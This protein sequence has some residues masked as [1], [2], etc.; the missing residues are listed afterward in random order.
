MVGLVFYVGR[1]QPPAYLSRHWSNR[2]TRMGQ[3][4]RGYVV[5]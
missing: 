4:V 1:A 2:I 3:G 5:S